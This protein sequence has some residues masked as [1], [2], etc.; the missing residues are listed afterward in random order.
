MS[1]NPRGNLTKVS[2]ANKAGTSVKTSI[3]SYLIAKYDISVGDH[4]EWFDDGEYIK[5]KKFEER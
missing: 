5:I 4:L 2:P 1:K 3:P